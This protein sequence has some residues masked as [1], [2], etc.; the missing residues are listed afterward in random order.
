MIVHGMGREKEDDYS[1]K[2]QKNL[3]EEMGF[4][5]KYNYRGEITVRKKAI[6]DI[7]FGKIRLR[8]FVKLGEPEKR[9]SFYQVRFSDFTDRIKEVMLNLEPK[10]VENGKIVKKGGKDS[11]ELVNHRVPLNKAGKFFVNNSLSDPILYSSDL[12]QSMRYPIKQAL[13][14]MLKEWPE[15]PENQKNICEFDSTP[16]NGAEFVVISSSLGSVMV[17]DTFLD[18]EEVGSKEM[19][20]ARHVVANTSAIFMMANQ[21][22]LLDLKDLKPPKGDGWF[23]SHKCEDD[24]ID[25]GIDSAVY[26]GLNI[27]SDKISKWKTRFQRFR[28][29]RKKLSK[30]FK[31]IKMDEVD[32][33][34]LASE[35]RKMHVVAFSDPNDLLT[36]N[37][38]QQF[39]ARCGD[40]DDADI[41]FVNVWS[42]NAR[43]WGF[44]ANPFKA[45]GGYRENDFVLELI[46]K[47]NS[48][49]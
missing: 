34:A 36:Y 11:D 18:M 40:A 43:P 10:I 37:L 17:F 26:E 38:D 47:G 14:W 4:E 27:N 19:D 13:C 35:L 46:R 12:G 8:E 42:S 25:S 20:S 31:A 28:G 6:T 41:N 7:E 29:F 24:N 44:F 9:L 32:G 21:L 2:L 3:A 48:H 1:F 22:P 33:S 16:K 39:A 49:K 5:E 23:D 15:D 30:K 45:H